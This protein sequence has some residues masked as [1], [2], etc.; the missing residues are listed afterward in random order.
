MKTG[1]K[2]LLEEGTNPRIIKYV[3]KIE[4]KKKARIEAEIA[5]KEVLKTSEVA[6]LLRMN[7]EAIYHGIK[8]GIIP[9]LKIGNK[10]RFNKRAVMEALKV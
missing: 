1:I 10:F 4:A 3:E 2:K 5:G 7:T 6:I 9:A 8:R